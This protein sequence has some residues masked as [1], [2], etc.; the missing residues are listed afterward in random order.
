MANYPLRLQIHLILNCLE[1]PR[2]RGEQ[3]GSTPE[4]RFRPDLTP[5]RFRYK[6]AE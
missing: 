5:S 2:S 1:N 3:L 4:T 6:G